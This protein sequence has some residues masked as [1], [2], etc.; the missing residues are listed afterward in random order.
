M[1]ISIDLDEVTFNTLDALLVFYYNKTGLRFKSTDFHTYDW[2]KVLGGSRADMIVL[3]YEFYHSPFFDEMI[4]VKDAIQSIK[5]LSEGGE[6]HI[7]TARPIDQKEKT[8]RSL[9]KHAIGHVPVAYSSDF[10]N[11]GKARTKVE[12]CQE[13]GIDTI[14]EDN[15]G[16]ALSCAEVGINA[17]LFDRP[18]NQDATHDNLVRVDGWKEAMQHL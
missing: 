17:I 14:I 8:D 2:W 1:K 7:V 9:Q 11:E 5:T 4:P 15:G 12:I 18:W 3:Y 10:Y 13:L 6:A 16:Y